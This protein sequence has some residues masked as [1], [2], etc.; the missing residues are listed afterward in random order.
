MSNRIITFE[1]DGKK[2][3]RRL[4]NFRDNHSV[5]ERIITHTENGVTWVSV[6]DKQW[7]KSES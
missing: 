6:K 3:T 5:G 1:R 4:S 7:V 2:Q